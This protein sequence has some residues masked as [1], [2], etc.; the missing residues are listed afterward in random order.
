MTEPTIA[1][2]AVV[3]LSIPID[4]IHPSAHQLRKRFD[5]Q[6]IASLAESMRQEGLIQP[7]TVRQ[8][9]GPRSAG[10]SMATYDDLSLSGQPVDMSVPQFELISGERRLRAA[11][12]LGVAQHRSQGHRCHQRSFCFR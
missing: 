7:I 3:V 4:Q 10:V 11:K 2:P 12:L 6:N 9:S 1:S 8:I 5:E